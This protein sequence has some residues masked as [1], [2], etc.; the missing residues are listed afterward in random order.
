MTTFTPPGTSANGFYP[1]ESIEYPGP[2]NWRIFG[3]TVKGQILLK[4]N[5]VK[6]R[7]GT[8]KNEDDRSKFRRLYAIVNFCLFHIDNGVHDSERLRDLLMEQSDRGFH[9]RGQALTRWQN[10][11]KASSSLATMDGFSADK[12]LS[13]ARSELGLD[14]N[15]QGRIEPISTLQRLVAG[16]L[17][18]V[19][20][21]WNAFFGLFRNPITAMIDA[22]CDPNGSYDNTLRVVEREMSGTMDGF[23]FELLNMQQPDGFNAGDCIIVLT[24]DRTGVRG[25]AST[26]ARSSVKS[27]AIYN[28]FR[29]LAKEK[30]SLPQSKELLIDIVWDI[31]GENGVIWVFKGED[32]NYTTTKIKRN[33]FLRE[34]LR[35]GIFFSFHEK[36]YE[37]FHH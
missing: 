18:G 30:V 6:L 29:N 19:R 37:H 5:T 3:V 7:P 11:R 8:D 26:A 1:D 32:G 16:G 36:F 13:N 10:S 24:D 31:V 23:S 12:L 27:L 33:D 15:L 2:G 9:L 25:I 22:Y 14:N 21:M 28:L 17:S 4:N 34:C 20:N 35:Y